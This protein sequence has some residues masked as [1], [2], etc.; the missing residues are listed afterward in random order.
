MGMTMIEKILANH[1]A[2]DTVRPGEIIDLHIDL[3]V[4]RDAGGASMVKQLQN[5]KLSIADA[6]KT[7]FTLD[8]NNSTNKTQYAEQLQICRTF[9]RENEI[10]V[11]ETHAGIGSHLMIDHGLAIP[12]NTM[13]STDPQ[14]N[15]IGA[16]GAFGQGMG[17]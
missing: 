12:G 16:I 6:T 5:S 7:F 17:E 13:L 2:Y 14:A 10:R 1:S 9:A 11:F 15:I 4:A 8:S 3:R